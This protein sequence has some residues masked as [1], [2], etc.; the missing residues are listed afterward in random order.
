MV[1]KK[2]VRSLLLTLALLFGVCIGVWCGVL[3]QHTLVRPALPVA[4]AGLLALLSV[5]AGRRVWS[6]L[7]RTDSLL[8]NGLCHL[9]CT[10]LLLL[11]AF[12]AA[13]YAFADDGAGHAER[14]VVA[15][16]QHVVRHHLRRVT[17]HHYA[18][19][20]AY[21]T[22]YMRVRFA[23]GQ[24]KKY[25]IPYSRYARLH[26]GDTIPLYVSRG[27]FGLPVVKFGHLFRQEP[28]AAAE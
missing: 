16:R 15:E 6:R 8:L 24:I 11:T 26:E 22:Y 9:L 19:G 27:L 25:R 10:G 4:V 2:K 14:V 28:R 5:A 3:A 21:D 12:Y 13:N 20:E 17:Q 7:T 1:M 18:R 23:D